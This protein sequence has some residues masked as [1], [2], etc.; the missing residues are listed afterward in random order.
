MSLSRVDNDLVKVAVNGIILEEV[1]QFASVRY[2]VGTS[3]QLSFLWPL[4]APCSADS[5]SPPSPPIVKVDQ[6]DINLSDPECV[7][8]MDKRTGISKKWHSSSTSYTVE[9]ESIRYACNFDGCSGAT[10]FLSIAS[11]KSH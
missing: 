11:G 8:V 4:S 2:P 3:L 9:N 1:G 6:V 7:S 5:R 10:L